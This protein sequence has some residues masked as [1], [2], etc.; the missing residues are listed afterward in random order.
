MFRVPILAFAA[1][2]VLAQTAWAEPSRLATMTGDYAARTGFSGTVLVQQGDAIVLKQSFG[3]ADRAFAVPN[4]PDTRYRIASITKLFTAALVLQLR[5]EGRIELDA[6][7]RSYLPRYAGN[8]AEKVPLRNL[9]NATSGLPN[10]DTVTSYEEA[11]AKGIPAYQTPAT[12]DQLLIKY[13]SGPLIRAPGREFDYNNADYIV[14]GKVVEA[15]T[16]QSFADALAQR[17][18]RPLGLANTGMLVQ[19]RVLPKLAS[20]YFR[21]DKQQTFVNDLP[22]YPEN[23]YAAGAMYATADDLSIFANSLFRKRLLKPDSLKHLLTPGLGEY[24]LGLWVRDIKVGQRLH[25]T[26]E[27]Y[28]SIMGAN[29]V[30]FRLLDDDLTIIILGNTNAA[31][32]GDFAATIARA[33]LER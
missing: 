30:L 10:M 4:E 2:T 17:I 1:L 8:G 5:D 15:V 29:G 16:G 13:A 28:G 31:D 12:T 24:G 14:L 26:A 3:L 11:V 20:T 27:R 19:S 33:I 7:V 9:L 32:P 21:P 23:W 6:P 18:L 25:R 22:M